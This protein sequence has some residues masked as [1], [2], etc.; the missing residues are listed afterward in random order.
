MKH[1]RG[2]T[3]VEV[4]VVSVI[5]IILASLILAN[6]RNASR[7]FE[8]QAAAQTLSAVLRQAQ[9]YALSARAEPLCSGSNPIPY[10]GVRVEE[11]QTLEAPYEIFA[12]CNQNLRYNSSDVTVE[13]GVLIK[14]TVQDTT[15]NPGPGDDWLE[16]VYIPPDPDVAIRRSLS[17]DNFEFELCHINDA[18]LC[19]E[20]A[21]N[22]K[23]NVEIQ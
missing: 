15:P 7:R 11:E 16:I 18:S 23:G 20:V 17:R 5:T 1:S 14:T 6:N 10:Y 2:F 9:G 22:D 3:V 12:D 8:I 4:L 21:G 19:V 13:S